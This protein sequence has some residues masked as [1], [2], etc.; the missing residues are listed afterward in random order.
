ML[1]L[2]VSE[3]VTLSLVQD[4]PQ[5]TPGAMAHSA[6]APSGTTK[7]TGFKL[8]TQWCVGEILA[9]PLPL[10]LTCGVPMA[11]QVGS[12]VVLPKQKKKKTQSF[13]HGEL[14]LLLGAFSFCY[15]CFIIIFLLH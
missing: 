12:A 15:Y 1:L 7:R 9:G 5:S 10:S 14:P 13:L 4:V 3:H 8:Q 11:C 2:M 6:I